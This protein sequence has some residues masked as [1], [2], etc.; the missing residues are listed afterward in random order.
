[1]WASGTVGLERAAAGE[2]APSPVGLSG[3]RRLASTAPAT[4]E[5]TT[6][7][8][9]AHA[10]SRPRRA[11]RENR[12]ATVMI[13]LPGPASTRAPIASPGEGGRRGGHRG[14]RRRK[15]AQ[16]VGV[17]RRRVVLVLRRDLEAHVH[18]IVLLVVRQ[19]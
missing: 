18:S 5:P 4:V 9:T 17:P 3:I 6:A 7:R 12:P 15:R 16:Q 13:L 11:N 14:G 1:E 2:A 10:A 8:A 19:V